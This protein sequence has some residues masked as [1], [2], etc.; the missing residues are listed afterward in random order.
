MK[1]IPQLARG[2]LRSLSVALVFALLFT[3][4]NASQRVAAQGVKV[5]RERQLLPF[6]FESALLAFK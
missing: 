1:M 4:S 5:G 3:T 6:E 2:V